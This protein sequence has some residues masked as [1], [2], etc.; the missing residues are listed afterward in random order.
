MIK[1]DTIYRKTSSTFL[2]YS[3]VISVIY[4][5]IL[6]YIDYI[7]K[8]FWYDE[9]YSIALIQYS[10][11][12]ILNITAKDVHPPLY[13]FLLK[14]FS[15]IFGNSLF[16]LRLFSSLGLFTTLLLGLFQIRRIFGDKVSF[17]FT[18][19]ICILPV[20]QYLGSEIR[21]YSWLMFFI[22][23]SSI[24]AYNSIKTGKKSEFVKFTALALCGAY[25]H[26]YGLIA[27]GSIYAYILIN[28]FLRKQKI[29]YCII[30]LVV[31]L[32][33]YGI[34]IP[35]LLSQILEVKEDYWIKAITLKDILLMSYYFFS[36]KEPSHP[37]LIFSIET[38]SI[39]LS[40][41]L[42]IILFMTIILITNRRK[43][44]K[45]KIRAATFF[46]YIFLFTI[47]ITL[48]ISLL[49]KP[50]LAPRFTTSVL[51][52]LVLSASIY[53]SSNWRIS[54]LF[55]ILCYS[56][57]FLFALFSFARFCSE[58]K[59]FQIKENEKKE[60]TAFVKKNIDSK[61]FIA[62]FELY[63]ELAKL[64]ILFPNNTFYLYSPN[65]KV[66]YVPFNVLVIEQIPNISSLIWIDN[67]EEKDNSVF[68][69]DE[70]LR[71]ELRNYHTDNTVSTSD[72]RINKLIKLN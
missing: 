25:T 53:T 70:D 44:K 60:L 24:Y 28:S 35:T 22:L 4:S 54:K 37:Y 16:T 9:A 12:D 51:G 6:L 32:L 33:I 42:I 29:S 64:S 13:Y 46:L 62:P 36:P 40:I 59:Y 67:P 7:N 48:L 65:D 1:S 52:V 26:N 69:N 19:L 34:W 10:Y 63:P 71:E 45:E 50:I 61:I 21:M 49:I 18:I 30:S 17:V 31:F 8:T 20:S 2:K 57:L 3:I 27:V 15:S 72:L 66:S 11:Q 14:A 56:I 38:M 39:A 47:G 68:L 55:R 58:K 23:S 43:I 5:L 41:A